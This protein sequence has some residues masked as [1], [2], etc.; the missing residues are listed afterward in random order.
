V[1]LASYWLADA[2][3]A[4]AVRPGVELFVRGA[5]LL[6]QRYQDAFSY[7]TELRALYAGI[8]LAGRRSSP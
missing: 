1:T 2:R 6:N 7:R 5:N 8:R 3:I 4:Y